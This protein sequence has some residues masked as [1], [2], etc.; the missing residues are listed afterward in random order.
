M[1]IDYPVDLHRV[2]KIIWGQQR[3][4]VGSDSVF[5]S[6]TS[7]IALP[8]WTALLVP[9]NLTAATYG[10]WEAQLLK[11]K[12]K[13]NRLAL[14]NLARPAP[15]GTMRGTMTFNGA[16]AYGDD[17][18]NISGGVG[19]AGKTLLAGDHLGFG[20]LTTQQVVKVL[21][22]AT[23]DGS[24]N[25]TV[26][27]E[28]VLRNAFAG[29]AAITWDKPKALFKRRGDVGTNTTHQP[30]VVNGMPLDLIENWIS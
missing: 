16:H 24:G 27:I 1:I 3:Y 12:G 26:N 4:E 30:G 18:L 13:Q 6:Q 21:D 11:L 22:D 15:L 20:S 2:A 25:I 28:S 23:A 10:A 17:V 8:N 29:G 14:W 7:E 19:E 5:G 9:V